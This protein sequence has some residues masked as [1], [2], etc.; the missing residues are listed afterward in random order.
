VIWAYLRRH[1]KGSH[2]LAVNRQ[3]AGC[4]EVAKRAR[5]RTLS[6]PH[7]Y[8]AAGCQATDVS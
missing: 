8:E 6:K 2:L 3:R 1:E 5:P 4:Q 7:P